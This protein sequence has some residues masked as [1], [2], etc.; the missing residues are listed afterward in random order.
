MKEANK[1]SWVKQY[2]LDSLKNKFVQEALKKVFGKALKYSS[3]Q[4]WVVSFIAGEFW[5]LV[6]RPI[7]LWGIRKSLLAYDKNKGEIQVKKLEEARREDNQTDY[8]SATDDIF[9]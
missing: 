8:D 2:L 5:D 6:G 1:N 3:F 7:V 9:R 4:G